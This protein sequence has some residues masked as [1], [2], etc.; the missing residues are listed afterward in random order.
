MIGNSTGC[1]T[2]T[3]QFTVHQPTWAADGLLDLFEVSFEQ[4]CEGLEPAL[5]GWLQVDAATPEPLLQMG[6]TLAK[7]GTVSAAGAD[8]PRRRQWRGI[9]SNIPSNTAAALGLPSGLRLATKG[10]SSSTRFCSS[11]YAMLFRVITVSDGGG[12]APAPALK[13]LPADQ[14]CSSGSSTVGAPKP[15]DA[16]LRTG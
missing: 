4:H 11:K 15:S 3:G 10:R 2:I 5:R 16:A 7:K 9:P 13:Q 8:P 12:R 1:N 14:I 6:V